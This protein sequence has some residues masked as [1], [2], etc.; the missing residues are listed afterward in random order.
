M[1]DTFAR[2][3]AKRAHHTS[4][5]ALELAR[6]AL[7][8]AHDTTHEKAVVRPRLVVGLCALCGEPCAHTKRYCRAHEWAA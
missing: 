2:A 1:T 8:I 6:T 3:T 5:Q 7:N 4:A